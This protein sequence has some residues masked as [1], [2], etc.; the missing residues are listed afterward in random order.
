MR[1]GALAVVFVLWLVA[2]SPAAASDWLPHASDATWTYSWTDSTYNTT[3]TKEK[4][5][6]KDT[7]GASFVLAWTTDGQENPDDAPV[8]IGT[9][10]FQDSPGGL[11]NTD[12]SSNPPPSSFPILCATLA[13][14]GNSLAS[15]FYNLIWGTRV[16]VLAEPLLQGTTWSSTGGARGDVT[17]ACEYVRTESVTVPAF[18]MPVTASKV[19]C[20]I[21]QAGALGDPYGSGVR[22]TWWVYGVGPVKIQFAHAGGV[23]APVTTSVLQSTNQAPKAPPGDVDYFPLQK[24]LKG[25]YRWTNTKHF[26]TPS[27]QSFVIDQVV[28]ASARFSFKSVSG[29][30]KVAGA[31]GFTSRLDGVTNLW[32][33]TKAAS[34]AKMPPLGPKSAAVDKRRHFHTPFDLMTFGFNPLLPAYPA[35]GNS[36][37]ADPAGR[38]F[39]IYGVS[40]TTAVTGVQSVR[41]PAG[42]FRALVVKSTLKQAGFPF[43]SG[44]R[45]SWFAPRKGLVKLVF[46][47]GD[48]SISTVELIK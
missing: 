18:T 46:R 6:V 29:P 15:T 13:S 42:S 9:I 44:T 3:P 20:E 40:G 38:D 4:V 7:K 23:S 28:N 22:T 25:T 24:G 32:G 43:G 26:K 11:I 17:S 45:T 5:T 41:V 21:T 16:P 19:Q 1:R 39:A 27:V 31:Y 34:L 30:L 33:L 36:W 8:S 14:C 48:G 10:S 12:W 2:A 47:H 35:A 37:R